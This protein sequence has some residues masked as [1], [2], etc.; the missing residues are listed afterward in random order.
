M[1]NFIF[2]NHYHWSSCL[3]EVLG[4]EFTVSKYFSIF[5]L[6]DRFCFALLSYNL[7]TCL[8]M[9][10][11][12]LSGGYYW[13][14]KLVFI[15]IHITIVSLVPFSVVSLWR[16][17]YKIY[18]QNLRCLKWFVSLPISSF[19]FFSFEVFSAYM[20][21]GWVLCL[22]LVSVGKTVINIIISSILIVQRLNDKNVFATSDDNENFIIKR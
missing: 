6:Y 11:I 17:K 14:H 5:I 20:K 7:C 19:L 10:F 15:S 9:L 21:R 13:N 22:K 12:W 18:N 1:T 2:K 3:D 4:M 8:I 16:H